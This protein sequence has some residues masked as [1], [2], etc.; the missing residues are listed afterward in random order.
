MEKSYMNVNEVMDDMRQH[1]FK[2]SAKKFNMMVDQGQLP[3]VKVLAVSAGGRR[4][5]SIFRR[6]YEAWRKEHLEVTA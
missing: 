4:T 3:F 6:D 5:Q 1:G 2:I